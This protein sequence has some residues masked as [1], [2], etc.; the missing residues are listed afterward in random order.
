MATNRSRLCTEPIHLRC[1]ISKVVCAVCLAG[2]RLVSAGIPIYRL[3][4]LP[5]CLVVPESIRLRIAIG[6]GYA[7][8]GPAKVRPRSHV[9]RS[10]V[11]L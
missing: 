5:L 2:V 4:G 11:M 6:S 7:C 9:V 8:F 1:V 3:L 10:V